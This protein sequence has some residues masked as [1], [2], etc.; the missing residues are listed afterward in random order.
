MK[1]INHEDITFEDACKAK[2]IDAI[3][4]LSKI[5]DMNISDVINVLSKIEYSDII[6]EILSIQPGSICCYKITPEYI[7]V[8]TK[9]YANSISHEVLFDAIYKDGHVI[10]EGHADLLDVVD[11]KYAGDLSRIN[12]FFKEDIND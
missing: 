8:I 4:E 2:I 10:R 9:V 12:E 7:F 6:S 1:I 3:N 5:Y 11:N